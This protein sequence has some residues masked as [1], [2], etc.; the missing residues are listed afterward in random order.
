ML[1]KLSV[2]FNQKRNWIRLMVIAFVGLVLMISQTYIGDPLNARA[3]E[4]WKEHLILWFYFTFMS[5]VSG[6]VVA[7]L[8]SFD[9]V[10]SDSVHLQRFKVMATTNLTVTMIVYW[11]LLFGPSIDKQ[12]AF[13]LITNLSVHLVTPM[14]LLFAFIYEA[15]KGNVVNKINIKKT[16]MIN[17]SFPLLWM[18][19]ATVLYYSLGAHANDAIYSFLRF[20][21]NAWYMST[22][23]VTGIA[24]AYVG[25]TSLFTWIYIKK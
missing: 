7:I 8:A 16:A 5:N 3:S 22:L 12:D 20:Q 21:Q 11:T 2:N 14:A 24:V 9:I 4:P 15:R 10:K 23:I 18:V 13:S 19:M 17:I 6:L 1:K 25:F